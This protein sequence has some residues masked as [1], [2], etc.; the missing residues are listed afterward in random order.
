MTDEAA[1]ALNSIVSPEQ[2]KTIAFTIDPIPSVHA[3]SVLIR[4]VWTNLLSN[5]VKYSSSSASPAIHIGASSD[6]RFITYFVKD[7]GAGFNQS[8]VD[9][10]FGIFQ[11]LHTA[12]QFPGIGIGLSIVKRIIER[13]NGR[14]WAEGKEREGATF[15][16]SLPIAP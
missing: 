4:Q 16:F 10:L 14:V 8:N 7:N 15:Y 3:D 6:G 9:K 1:A 5:A 11:R 12:A 2:R 13:H